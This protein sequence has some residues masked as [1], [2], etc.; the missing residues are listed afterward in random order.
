M[1]NLFQKHQKF[2][3][4][5]KYT[6]VYIVVNCA[7]TCGTL[8]CKYSIT[9]LVLHN[10]VSRCRC[11]YCYSY[12][13]AHSFTTKISKNKI[14]QK[15]KNEKKKYIYINKLKCFIQ[16]FMF[17]LSSIH[18]YFKNSD[19]TFHKFSLDMIKQKKKKNKSKKTLRKILRR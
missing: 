17:S 10:A 7:S 6:K 15:Y 18:F 16:L 13:C 3:D 1:A 11:H 8:H 2:A 12:L 14:I 19:Q 9:L 4:C 5:F